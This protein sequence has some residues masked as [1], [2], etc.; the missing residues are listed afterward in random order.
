M[1]W[2]GDMW[3]LDTLTPLAALGSI[4][5]E[6]IATG[7]VALSGV[8]ALLGLVPATHSCTVILEAVFGTEFSLLFA[9]TAEMMGVSWDG[10]GDTAEGDER[11]RSPTAPGCGVV[12]K[13]VYATLSTDGWLLITALSYRCESTLILSRV[14]CLCWD[15][16]A[17]VDEVCVDTECLIYD[18]GGATE[19]ED[20]PPV[21]SPSFPTAGCLTLL[22]LV[23][24]FLMYSFF[25][26]TVSAED[27]V[28]TIEDCARGTNGRLAE[29]EAGGDAAIESAEGDETGEVS[30]ADGCSSLWVRVVPPTSAPAET[31][32]RAL[33]PERGDVSVDPD[34][35]GGRGES[36]VRLV[37]LK[38]VAIVEEAEEVEVAGRVTSAENVDDVANEESND[39]LSVS[40]RAN[41]KPLLFRLV[42]TRDTFRS[43]LNEV[44]DFEGRLCSVVRFVDDGVSCEVFGAEGRL[45]RD[46]RVEESSCGGADFLGECRRSASCDV[47]VALDC[48]VTCVVAGVVTAE[49]DTKCID[50]KFINVGFLFAWVLLGTVATS[51]VSNFNSEAT[52]LPSPSFEMSLQ[53]GISLS[54]RTVVAVVEEKEDISL[55]ESVDREVVEEVSESET[56]GSD[57]R[58]PE[59]GNNDTDAEDDEAPTFGLFVLGGLPL[60]LE[61]E[62]FFFFV[63]VDTSDIKFTEL[64]AFST[65]MRGGETTP[66]SMDREGPADNCSGIFLSLEDDG[67]C[68]EAVTT[69]RLP[70]GRI[71]YSWKITKTKETKRKKLK[72]RKRLRAICSNLIVCG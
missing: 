50:S 8:W 16:E 56:G 30:R 33:G 59:S 46:V 6:G 5:Y 53:R 49:L 68:R 51:S 25:E 39:W 61:R 34:D 44:E 22:E 71:L 37:R 66:S 36:V 13:D 19:K 32:V 12:P 60:L 52:S 35:R 48:V 54:D 27:E 43:G 57:G 24:I 65:S 41:T 58:F 2:G 15:V 72:A 62:R 3:L 47:T 31:A 70:S 10:G 11:G 69:P 20:Q 21:A 55:E 67:C 29:L 28:E 17:V 18:D 26:T 1:T 4:V 64:F 42:W 38:E 14:W 9:V 7:L 40:L 63:E 23:Y 45:S